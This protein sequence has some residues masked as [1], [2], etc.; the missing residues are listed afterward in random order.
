MVDILSSRWPK[1]AVGQWAVSSR[2]GHGLGEDCTAPVRASSRALVCTFWCAVATGGLLQG[3]SERMVSAGQ[4]MTHTH[5]IPRLQ[6]V[7]PLHG[8]I[9]G[10]HWW[11]L[12]VPFGHREAF[13]RGA[14]KAFV[15]VY[16]I[17]RWTPEFLWPWKSHL[18]EQSALEK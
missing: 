17:A 13:S 4:R 3:R 10:R 18:P 5:R 15:D 11:I 12:S 14:L 2:R 1:Q 16:T 9:L 6:P 8:M 7:A